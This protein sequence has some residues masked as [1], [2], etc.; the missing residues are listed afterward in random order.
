MAQRAWF[1]SLSAAL[2]GIAAAAATPKTVHHCIHDDIHASFPV[3]IGARHVQSNPQVYADEH[4]SS[5]N[6]QQQAYSPI[7]ITLDTSLLMVN[8]CV[9][10]AA[11]FD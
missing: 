2:V 8:A 3:L 1:H 5:R 11:W 6:L 4:E 9:G 10:P 7:R